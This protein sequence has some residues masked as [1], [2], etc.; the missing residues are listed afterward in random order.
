MNLIE[1]IDKSENIGLVSHVQPDGDAIGSSNGLYLSLKKYGKKVYLINNSDQPDYLSFLDF[2]SNYTAEKATSLDLL[3]I[4]DLNDFP[5][6][7]KI[8]NEWRS[9]ANNVACIDHHYSSGQDFKYS[10][11]NSKASSTCQLVSEFIRNNELPIDSEIASFLYLGIAT[12][13]NRFLYDNSRREAMSES[14]FLIENGADVDRIYRNLY[15]NKPVNEL[16][17]QFDVFNRAKFVENKRGVIALVRLKDFEKYGADPS[18]STFIIQM[19]MELKG[20]EVACLIKEKEDSY[21][22]SLRSKS[23]LNVANIAE[24]FNGGGH[25]HAAGLSIEHMEEKKIVKLMEDRLR[26]AL[27]WME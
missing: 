7:G 12:D 24:E 16:Q 20:L 5:R 9:L 23:D 13:T 18:C 17:L 10:Y 4:L 25:I 11:I 15:S 26:K 1:I 19:L 21:K 8:G 14:I 6:I 2:A 27:K 22:I 3:I